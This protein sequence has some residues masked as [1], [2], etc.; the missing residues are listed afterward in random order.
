M[1]S[2]LTQVEVARAEPAANAA[3]PIVVV[4]EYSAPP[5]C[6]TEAQFRERAERSSARLRW[7]APAEGSR[8]YRVL[9]DSG[10]GGFRG[11]LYEAGK[12][13]PRELEVATCEELVDALSLM[14]VLSA[15]AAPGDAGEPAAPI[16]VDTEALPTAPLVDLPTAARPPP[17]APAA[18][19]RPVRP[20]IPTGHL[21][22][23]N[24]LGLSALALLNAAP[25]TLL[26]L[27]FGYER[28]L[29]HLVSLRLEARAA[30]GQDR[31]DQTYG[32]VAPAV[33]V[34]VESSLAELL[35]CGGLLLGYL[36]V[37]GAEYSGGEQS[38]YCVTP[39]LGFKLRRSI[40]RRLTVELGAELQHAFIRRSYTVKRD[41]ST[42]ETPAVSEAFQLGVGARF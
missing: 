33:C 40:G 26:G 14:L 38:S 13:T 6:P 21:S 17:P 29:E 42:F 10:P 11:Q 28:A 32:G 36:D 5:V 8:V 12:A 4:L 15:D 16:V 24:L 19:A 31:A 41:D 39:L 2:L 25:D 34:R 20:R 3:K 27:V 9:I 22:N 23:P 30:Q 18:R 35:G 7:A 37:K 1:A